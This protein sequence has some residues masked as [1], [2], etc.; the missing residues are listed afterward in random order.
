LVFYG[1]QE[2]KYNYPNSI[3]WFVFITYTECLQSSKYFVSME[4]ILIS[5]LRGLTT[6]LANFSQPLVWD[7]V[8][9]S[10]KNTGYLWCTKGTST[11]I[12]Q[13]SLLYPL[14]NIL[15]MNRELIH[16]I[17]SSKSR[18][19]LLRSTSGFVVGK[20]AAVLIYFEGLGF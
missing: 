7:P 13:V 10:G 17:L 2:K 19:K 9:V 18:I 15:S 12:N 16:R 8:S 1:Y 4:V 6:S 20:V 5:I 3:N 14:S 11:Y